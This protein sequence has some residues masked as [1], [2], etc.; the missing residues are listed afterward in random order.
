M[1]SKNRGVNDVLIF[2]VDGLPGFPESINAVLPH[3]EI[4]RCL[5]HQVRYSLLHLSWK[6]RKPIGMA[7]KAIHTAP[8]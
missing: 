7:L 1:K 5:V 6:D 3:S 2:S 4:Q 8:T